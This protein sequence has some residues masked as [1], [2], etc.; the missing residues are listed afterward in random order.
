MTRSAVRVD[1]EA[2]RETY[3]ETGDAEELLRGASFTSAARAPRPG[4]WI[5][6]S[7][8]TLGPPSANGG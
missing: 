5:S 2:S 3:L 1:S 4:R 8:G 7:M 6:C